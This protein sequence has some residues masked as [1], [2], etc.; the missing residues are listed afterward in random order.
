MHFAVI[1][2]FLSI[3][4]CIDRFPAALSTAAIT[5]NDHSS[6]TGTNAMVFKKVAKRRGFR[7]ILMPFTLALFF[8]GGSLF[9]IA[10]F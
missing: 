10:G 8:L 3:R 1:A 7:R 5:H 2:T 9:L 6:V 4:K